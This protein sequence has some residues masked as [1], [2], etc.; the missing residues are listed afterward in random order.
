[1]MSVSAGDEID[2]SIAHLQGG[3]TATIHDVTSGQTQTAPTTT[4]NFSNL[5][6]A[7]WIQEDPSLPHNGHVPYPQIA[8]VTMWRLLANGVAPAYSGLQPQWM[9]LPHGQRVVPDPLVNDRFTTTQEA[10]NS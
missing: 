6:L 3:W 9:V 1:M 4:G 5:Q 10:V 7:E 2:A 8:P